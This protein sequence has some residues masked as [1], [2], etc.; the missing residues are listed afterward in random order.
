MTDRPL[1]RLAEAERLLR[2]VAAWSEDDLESLPPL[3]RKYARQYQQLLKEG[4]PE[5]V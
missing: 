3:Y 4:D 5:H 1:H 2:A